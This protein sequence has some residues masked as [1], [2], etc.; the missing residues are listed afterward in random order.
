MERSP[1]PVLIGGAKLAAGLAPVIP[2]RQGAEQPCR[3]SSM[4][5][6]EPDTV[7]SCPFGCLGGGAS[8]S[9]AAGLVNP[10]SYPFLT[11]TSTGTG[12]RPRASLLFVGQFKQ[13]GIL[14]TWEVSF[15]ALSPPMKSQ[16]AART[17]LA[18]AA[19]SG[20]SK[21]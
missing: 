10:P 4:Q 16:R 13:P 15:V 5:V 8:A 7:V 19:A 20:R 9:N 21:I 12:G 14:Q 2:N 3:A 11:V 17:G 6:N 1:N 18:S